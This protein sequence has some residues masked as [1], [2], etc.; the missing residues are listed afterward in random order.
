[1]MLAFRFNCFCNNVHIRTS[2][3]GRD[4][5]MVV[6]YSDDLDDILVHSYRVKAMVSPESNSMLSP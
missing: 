5:D 6:D 2:I 4:E 1:M 3:N